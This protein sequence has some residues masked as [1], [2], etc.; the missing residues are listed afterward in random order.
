MSFVSYYYGFW[1]EWSLY[2]KV[3]FDG[4][5]K[6][7][8]VNRGVTSLDIKVDVYSDWKEWMQLRTHTKFEAALRT[9]GGDPTIGGQFL[10]DTYFLINGWRF[11]TWEDNRNLA[12]NGNIFVDGV[13]TLF[14]PTIRPWT[15]QT[16]LER[17]NLF[18]VIVVSG[19]SEVVS[20]SFT[21]TDRLLLQA[22][23]SITQNLPNSGSLTDIQSGI[24]DIQSELTVVSGNVDTAVSS[25]QEVNSAVIMSS[26]MVT[27]GGM[28]IVETT[29]FGTDNVFD[30]MFV[31]ISSGSLQVVRK[32]EDFQE[33]NGTITFDV[34]LPFSAISGSSGVTILPG[35]NPVNGGIG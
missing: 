24:T 30:N 13:G 1:D 33:A 8:L 26:G 18:D 31:A 11:R 34:A 5:N 28:D 17:S 29:V 4:D 16:S 19:S 7:I 6:L 3:T 10:G 25:I 14:V 2:H 27:S 9:V 22:I 21:S 12:L 20:G 23:D 35:Y 15:I 32:V